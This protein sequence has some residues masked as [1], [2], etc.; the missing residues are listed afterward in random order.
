MLKPCPFCGNVPCLEKRPLWRSSGGSAHGYYGCY[1]YVIKCDRVGCGC[2]VNLGSNDTVYRSDEEA[3]QN[4][5]D[6][7]NRR[8]E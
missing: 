6:A 4:A 7:W 8:F 2:S 3:K 5:I 1:E